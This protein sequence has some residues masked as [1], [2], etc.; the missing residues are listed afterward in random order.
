MNKEIEK[1]CNTCKHENKDFLYDEPC[2]SCIGTSDID[3]VPLYWK[4]KREVE[5][6]ND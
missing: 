1:D 4:K 3:G 5:N 2:K 6:Y